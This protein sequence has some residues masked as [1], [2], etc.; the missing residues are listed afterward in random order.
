MPLSLR[1]KISGR[2]RFLCEVLKVS[3][4]GFYGY[5]LRQSQPT[6]DVEEVTLLNRVK[7]IAIKTRYCYGSRRMAKALQE[8]GFQVGR[9]KARRLMKDAGIS[10][11]RAKRR[12][13]VTTDSR[14]G[15]NIAP[16]LLARQFDVDGPGIKP[17]WAI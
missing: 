12:A 15:Y 14:H 8:E 7:A 6:I 2:S 16:N 5:L 13:P 10:V 4:S 1:I 9:V 11:K 3:R 17:G